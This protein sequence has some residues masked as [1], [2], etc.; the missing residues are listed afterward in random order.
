VAIIPVCTCTGPEIGDHRGRSDPGNWRCPA[1]PKYRPD[2]YSAFPK[3]RPFPNYKILSKRILSNIFYR[4]HA[5]KGSRKEKPSRERNRKV[6]K[7]KDVWERIA[8]KDEKGKTEQGKEEKGFKKHKC[9]GKV[10]EKVSEEG[11]RGEK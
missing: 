10:C 9:L 11:E 8:R 5:E 4:K 3:N 7:N 2:D 1:A 6:S